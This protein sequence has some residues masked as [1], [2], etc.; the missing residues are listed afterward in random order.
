MKYFVSI[1]NI[2]TV[3]NLIQRKKD[4]ALFDND[5]KCQNGLGW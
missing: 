2:V 4:G 5:K 3:T 1:V